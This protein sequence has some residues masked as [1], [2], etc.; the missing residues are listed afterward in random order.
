MI[1]SSLSTLICF[2]KNWGYAKCLHLSSMLLVLSF[3]SQFQTCYTH[4][5]KIGTAA[6]LDC[7]YPYMQRI[8]ATLDLISLCFFHMTEFSACVWLHVGHRLLSENIGIAV[9]IM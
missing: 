4:K 2:S 9:A 5:G 6:Q 7:S 1:H 8:I 3:W